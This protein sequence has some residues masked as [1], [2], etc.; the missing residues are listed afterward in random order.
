MENERFHIEDEEMYK[1][2]R[3]VNLLTKRV[4]SWWM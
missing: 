4:T 1:G 2:V 3:G